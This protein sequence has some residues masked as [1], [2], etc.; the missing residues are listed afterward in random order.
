MSAT[1][2]ATLCLAMVGTSFI[3]GIFGMAGGMILMGI[4]FVLLPVPEAMVLHGVTQMA[5][6]GWRGLLWIRY[7]RWAPVAAY[8]VGA[9]IAL[10]AWWYVRYVPSTPVAL[11]MLGLT[12]FL[13]WL[14][15]KNVKPNPES[16]WQGAACGVISIS[17]MLLAGVSGPLIDTFFL[18]GKFD[19]REIVATKAICQVFSHA[20][21]LLYFGG[22]ISGAAALDPVVAL[23]AIASAMLG[24]GLAARV[25]Q[26][27]SD[28][29]YRAWSNRI[30]AAIAGY[31]IAHALYLLAVVPTF[32][33]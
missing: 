26:A 2:I 16:P 30:V 31:Y 27:M 24:T 19:R 22:L 10:A 6:N 21:K 11:L 7:V 17:L 29:Q 3:S 32:A 15:P 13:I 1:L 12:P 9:L 28:N 5:S 23:L 8:S 20:L 18:A 33:K 4:L 14:A 25:L